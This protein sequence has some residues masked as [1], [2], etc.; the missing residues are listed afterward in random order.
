LVQNLEPGRIINL[1]SC[2]EI[3]ASVKNNITSF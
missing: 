2:M 3:K 1:H